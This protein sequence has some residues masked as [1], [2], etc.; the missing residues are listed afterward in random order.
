MRDR[1]TGEE[2]ARLRTRDPHLRRALSKR[3]FMMYDQRPHARYDG[4][5]ER[6]PEPIL[7]P[8]HELSR[9]QIR[10]ALW[11]FIGL[12]ALIILAVVFPMPTPAP[13]V[14]THT[15]TADCLSA[16]QMATRYGWQGNWCEYACQIARLN[17]WRLHD[18]TKWP[19]LHL[20]EKVRVPDY[21]R[22]EMPR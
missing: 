20:G 13:R 4:L 8:P 1:L 9:W 14:V 22:K 5:P 16:Q 3:G 2:M 10:F 18:R 15:I 21:R 11:A 19:V 7:G 17:G 6:L 12:M